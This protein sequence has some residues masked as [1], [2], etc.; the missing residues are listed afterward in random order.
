[1]KKTI[2]I[3]ALSLV[4]MSLASIPVYAEGWERSGND[5][6]YKDSNNTMVYDAWKKGADGKWRWINSNGVMAVN[7]WADSEQYY[8]D[9]N[10]VMM[11]NAWKQIQDSSDS[12][13]YY[14]GSN[15]KVYKDG[16]KKIDN[17]NYYFNSEGQMQTGWILD[18]MYYIGSDG[19][20]KTGW[21]FLEN[22]GDEYNS[23]KSYSPFDTDE[24]KSWFYFAGNGKKYK[25]DT[26]GFV[27]KRIDGKRYCFSETGAMQIGWVNMRGDRGIDGN[28]TDYKY[29][30][31][32]G[33]A[34]TGWYSIEP[35][36]ELS[37]NYDDAVEWFYFTSAG[38]PKASESNRYLVRD[39]Q[40]INNKLYLF[41]EK[42]NPVYGLKKLYTGNNDKYDIYYF[43]NPSQCFVHKGKVQVDIGGSSESFYFQ[44]STGKG[45]TGVKNGNLYYK[46]RIQKADKESRYR[47]VSIP[48]ETSDAHTNYVVTTSG[49]IVKSGKVKDADKAEY[50][51]NAQGILIKLDGS[52]DGIRGVFD[53][54]VEVEVE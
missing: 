10:G 27:E 37:Q 40:K 20:M 11:E 35:P 29:F 24:D 43:G 14:F 30:N 13:W 15:G 32:D 49:K 1:M 18:D 36:E 52:T 6:I 21:Q 39:L 5:W 22:P 17:K 53:T 47:V 42:G 25:P 28:I 9:A 8:V 45:Y 16:W 33:T 54:P 34:R 26:D 38:V 2:L 46:G 7:S 41:D 51:T 23:S 3:P 50:Q 19:I 31:K 4:I 12:A 44:E 48:S